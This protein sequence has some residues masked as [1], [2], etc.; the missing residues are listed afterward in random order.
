M[1]PGALGGLSKCGPSGTQERAWAGNRRTPLGP[2]VAMDVIRNTFSAILH[3]WYAYF[4]IITMFFI[5]II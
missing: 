1:G 2:E 5:N 3:F 4:S